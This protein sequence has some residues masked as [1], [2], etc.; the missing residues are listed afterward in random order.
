[1]ELENGK[2]Q[3]AASGKRTNLRFDWRL[4]PMHTVFARYTHDGNNSFAPNG[5]ART[6][7]SLPSNWSR[8]NN[9]VDQSLIALTSVLSPTIVNDLRFS[10]FFDSGSEA[11]VYRKH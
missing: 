11:P 3:K 5:A 1:M 4:H 6:S 8:L 7:T 9:F 10:Y 2:A